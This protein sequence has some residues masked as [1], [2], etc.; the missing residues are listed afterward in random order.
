MPTSS[1]LGALG[2]RSYPPGRTHLAHSATAPILATVSSG[3]I[4]SSIYQPSPAGGESSK[5]SDTI[6]VATGVP[7][8]KRSMIELIVSGRYVDL[9]ELPPAKGFTKPL[10]AISSALEGQVVLLQAADYMQCKRLIPDLATWTQCFSIYASVLLTKHPERAQSL[11]MYMAQIAKLSRKFKWPSWI[12]YDD[13]FR[14]EAADEGKLDWS[15]IDGTIYPQC[16]NG[17]AISEEAWCTICNSM[18]H[19]K[20]SCP[21]RPPD[22]PQNQKRPSAAP[23]PTPKRPRSIGTNQAVCRKWNR[24]ESYMDCSFGASCIYQHVCSKCFATDH[25]AAKCTNPQNGRSSK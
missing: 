10:S 24:K 18:D 5:A 13:K 21:Y 11:L 20:E 15:K 8:L 22:S 12:A 23:K 4:I 25:G 3:P 1:I 16:F 14:R 2:L 9:G 19:L 7:A 17:M 6:V